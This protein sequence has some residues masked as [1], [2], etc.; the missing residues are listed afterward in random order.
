VLAALGLTAAAAPLMGLDPWSL[1]NIETGFA[2]F[3]ASS[4]AGA[5]VE[6]RR[7]C[8]SP[9][10]AAGYTCI[11]NQGGSQP[12]SGCRPLHPPTGHLRQLSA[13]CAWLL[14]AGLSARML[15]VW[16]QQAAE[17]RRLRA[18][19]AEF[20][21]V[22]SMGVGPMD[23]GTEEQEVSSCRAQAG[24]GETCTMLGSLVVTAPVSLGSALQSTD[25]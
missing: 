10:L 1:L 24:G 11:C 5:G 20:E 12:A 8:N 14:P 21:R 7:F 17:E 18:S 22:I 19:D 13:P 4:L 3:T 23:T 16:M 2:L 25:V 9:R 6:G 15:P